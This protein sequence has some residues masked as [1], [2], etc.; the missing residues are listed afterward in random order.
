MSWS[1]WRVR[2]TWGPYCAT[3]SRADLAGGVGKHVGAQTVQHHVEYGD[4]RHADGD[5]MQRGHPVMHQHLVH[6][7]L[8]EQRCDEGEQLDEQR[9]DEDFPQDLA[10]FHDRRNEPAEIEL[11]QLTQHRGTRGDQQQSSAIALIELF[12]RQH[13]GATQP[14]VLDKHLLV[15]DLGDDEVLTIGL[16][17]HGG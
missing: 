13:L 7:D 14:Q 9:N 3:C 1:R 5:D 15:V 8:V 12:A 17:R 11:G 6:H 4:G 16:V 10:V 2:V